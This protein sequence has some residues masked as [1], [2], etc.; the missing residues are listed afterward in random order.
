MYGDRDEPFTVLRRLGQRLEDGGLP[1][2]ILAGIVETVAVAMKL[3][4]AEITLQHGEV[5]EQVARYGKGVDDVDSFAIHYQGQTIGNLNVGLRGSGESLAES[6][7]GLLRQIASQAGP[8]AHAVQL[9]RDLRQSRARVVTAREEERRRLHRDLHDGLGPVL[10]SQGLKIAAVSHL[11]KTDPERAQ[12]I[13]DELAS[14]NESVVAD[15]RRLVYAL[16]PP[17]LEKLGL[18]EAVRDYAAGLNVEQEQGTRFRLHDQRPGQGSEELPAAVEVAAYR[19]ATEALTNVTRHAKARRCDVSFAVEA[20][21]YGRQLRLEIVDDGVGIP[22]N[23][24]QG[25]GLS[26]MRARAEEA[27]GKIQVDSTVSQGTRVV[28]IFPLSG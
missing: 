10:A 4:Y 13:L 8:I 18:V 21:D 3:P 25:V 15:I 14:Q 17:E 27:G 2:E 23:G 22:S 28:A 26:S 20:G 9:T 11:L 1:E 12:Q 24:K 7:Q 16:H 5:H 19:I 6:D